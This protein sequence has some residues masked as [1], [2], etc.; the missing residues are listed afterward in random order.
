MMYY[1]YSEIFSYT[2]NTD[3]GSDLYFAC[4]FAFFVNTVCQQ[5]PSSLKFMVKN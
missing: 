3:L 4:L 2:K 5:D 1:D